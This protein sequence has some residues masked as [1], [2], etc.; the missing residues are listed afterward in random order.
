MS[1]RTIGR[2]LNQRGQPVPG[3][4]FTVAGDSWLAKRLAERTGPITSHPTRP[5]W[6]IP[7]SGD[8]GTIR[9]LSVFGSGYGGPP[10]HYHEQSHEVFHVEEGSITVTLDG[11][12]QRVSAGE[13]V[14]VETGVVHSFTN[15]TDERALVTTEIRAPGRLREV[16]PT[17]GGLA[18]DR[19]R[20]VDD[21][22]Q[23]VA[24]AERLD[25]NTVFTEQEG[26][27]GALAG[28]LAP[29]A[30]LAGYQGAYAKYAQPAF[31]EAHVEQP[32]T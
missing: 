12:D 18:H 9:T 17:L 1:E 23:Q 27:T 22:L 4:G 19:E 29:V 10:E 6:G 7:L 13:S 31:W 2:T 21:P 11:V 32:E 5:V 8:S 26:L 14:T 30:Q 3:T 28:A 20:D 24:I 16:L 25:G 15:D